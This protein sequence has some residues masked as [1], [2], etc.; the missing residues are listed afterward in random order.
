MPALVSVDKQDSLWHFPSLDREGN[1]TI[2]LETLTVSYRC[3][4]GALGKN[5]GCLCPTPIQ[6]FCSL[7][8]SDQT[9][10]SAMPNMC[11]FFAHWD[12][13]DCG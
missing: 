1:S 9:P 10:Q 4:T 3:K 8:L 13:S 11:G 7:H 5:R 6:I 2:Y 12:G